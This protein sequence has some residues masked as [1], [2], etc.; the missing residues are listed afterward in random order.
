M[1]DKTDK[2]DAHIH[3]TTQQARQLADRQTKHLSKVNTK[4]LLNSNAN[5]G[6]PLESLAYR[7]MQIFLHMS[8]CAHTNTHTYAQKKIHTHAYL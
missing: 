1:T 6:V 2:A 8:A 5:F 7:G 4:S 3:R